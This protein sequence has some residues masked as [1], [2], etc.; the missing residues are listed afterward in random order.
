MLAEE[1]NQLQPT[2]HNTIQVTDLTIQLTMRNNIAI[3]WVKQPLDTE[4]SENL[5]N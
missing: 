5:A 3:S 2:P 4:S 1:M